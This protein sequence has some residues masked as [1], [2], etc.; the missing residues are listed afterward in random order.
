[1]HAL[2]QLAARG[3]DLVQGA[4]MPGSPEMTRDA[5]ISSQASIKKLRDF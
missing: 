1:M 2:E 3:L 5:N 4:P